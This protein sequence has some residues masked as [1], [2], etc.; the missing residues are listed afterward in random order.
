MPLNGAFIISNRVPWR[1]TNLPWLPL[2]LPLPAP[3]HDRRWQKPKVTVTLL[4]HHISHSMHRVSAW[5]ASLASQ[6]PAAAAAAWW[7]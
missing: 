3:Q 5:H 1:V 2:T 4:V 6:R 7:P